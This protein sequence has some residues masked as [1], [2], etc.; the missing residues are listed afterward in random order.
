MVVRNIDFRLQFYST[1][2]IEIVFS[3]LLSV[4]I[5]FAL[6][7]FVPERRRIR[8]IKNKIKGVR[9]YVFATPE[10]ADFEY[11]RSSQLRTLLN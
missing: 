7:L 9:N 1:F 2:V 8:H 11:K 6:D 10:T 3:I 4:M 5:Q